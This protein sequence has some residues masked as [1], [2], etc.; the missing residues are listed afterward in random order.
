MGI[1]SIEGNGTVDLGGAALTV[2]GNNGSTT[3]SG[4]ISGSGGSLV[5]TGTGTFTVSG[6]NLFTGGTTVSQGTLLLNGSLASGVTVDSGGTFG[7]TG[8]VTG[9]LINSG[10]VAPGTV[11]SPLTINGNFTQNA[12]GF[13]QVAL[14]SSGATRLVVNGTANLGGSVS[15][16]AGNG[17]SIGTRYTILTATTITGS[18]SVA[19]SNFAFLTPSLSY[20]STNAYLTLAIAA[21]AFRRA[22]TTGNQSAVGAVLDRAFPTATGDFAT[23]L[24]AVAVLDTVQG[25]HALEVIGGQNYSGFSTVATQ[26]GHRLHEQLRHAGRRAASAEQQ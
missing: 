26:S 18:F 13:Y 7:G 9:D 17:Y 6:A 23:V 21:D 19:R 25:P 16:Q 22:A 1:G 24:N 8:T 3:Y 15:V 11:G 5:K 10:T 14:N 2:G 4:V 12:G 20:D